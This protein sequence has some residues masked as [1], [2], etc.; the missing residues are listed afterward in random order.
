MCKTS[1]NRK[2]IPAL[3]T[4]N[5]QDLEEMTKVCSGFCEYAQVD[6]MDGEFVAS[7][8]IGKESLFNFNSFVAYELHLM[9][10]DPLAWVESACHA[11]A[12]RIIYHYE[13]DKDHQE[14][15]SRVKK[16]GLSVG[17]AVNPSTAIVELENIIDKI[18]TVLFMSVEPG[19]YGASFKPEVLEKIKEFKSK[20]P[21]KR[22]GIDG[23]VKF[24]NFRVI[25]DTGVDDI[26]VGSAILKAD[27]PKIAYKSFRE[28]LDV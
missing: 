23:G 9:V 21:K 26:C 7:K 16:E 24:D 27:N 4:D 14:I 11:K 12:K 5:C 6:I 1:R 25:K 8:S 17:V 10:V 20:Y 22:I 28:L 13:I 2:I 19:F 15:I 18:D 3:L